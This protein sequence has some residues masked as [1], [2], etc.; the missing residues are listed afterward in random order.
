MLSMTYHDLRYVGC[1]PPKGGAFGE[2]CMPCPVCASCPPCT[3]CASLHECP[4]R[5]GYRFVRLVVQLRAPSAEQP[6]SVQVTH[7]GVALFASPVPVPGFVCD[8]ACELV[9]SAG[10]SSDFDD[11][12]WVDNLLIASSPENPS[13]APSP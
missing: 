10:T 4:L 12:H 8:D 13:A 1:P 5:A 6:A 7:D 9:L 3:P 2:S 11:D